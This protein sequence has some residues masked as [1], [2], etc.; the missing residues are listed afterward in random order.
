MVLAWHILLNRADYILIVHKDGSAVRRVE[1]DDFSRLIPSA[2]IKA[3]I[4][5]SQGLRKKCIKLTK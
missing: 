5:L 4:H 2:G 1:Q 3:H